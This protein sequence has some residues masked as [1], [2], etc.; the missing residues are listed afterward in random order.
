MSMFG[1]AQSRVEKLAAVLGLTTTT[2]RACDTTAVHQEWG[3]WRDIQRLFGICRGTLYTLKA[4]GK[5]RSARV[6]GCRLFDVASVRA[7]VNSQLQ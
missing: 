7:Y 6:H 2:A 1:E 5:I 4:E 3:R